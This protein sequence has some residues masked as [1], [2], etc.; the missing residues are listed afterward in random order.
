MYT[1]AFNGFYTSQVALTQRGLP[2]CQPYRSYSQARQVSK[3]ATRVLQTLAG[4]RSRP[5][6][7]RSNQNSR[8]MIHKKYVDMDPGVNNKSWT[9]MCSRKKRQKINLKKQI[10]SFVLHLPFFVHFI[11]FKQFHGSER[12]ANSRAGRKTNECLGFM[13]RLTIQI[14]GSFMSIIASE[15]RFYPHLRCQA[16]LTGW[17]RKGSLH[18]TSFL[19]SMFILSHQMVPRNPE[20]NTVVEGW[21]ASPLEISSFFP[22]NS[23]CV[24]KKYYHKHE[25]VV[26][27]VVK[28]PQ[29]WKNS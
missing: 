22:I 6:N 9:K 10:P 12:M 29:N 16:K 2:G 15:S 19:L 8:Q 4:M 21:Q 26:E 18:Q 23:T 28:P 27:S 14:D 1:G 7:L 5:T 25:K 17:W 24:N 13:H 20:K 3:L 11:N